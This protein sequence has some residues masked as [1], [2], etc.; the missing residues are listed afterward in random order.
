M[1][2]DDENI[3]VGFEQC[4]QQMNTFINNP[5]LEIEGII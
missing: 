3:A 2:K 5:E 1:K 4:F